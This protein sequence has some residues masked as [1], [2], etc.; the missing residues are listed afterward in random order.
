MKSDDPPACPKTK[1]GTFIPTLDDE[2]R[3][4]GWTVISM[5]NDWQRIFPFGS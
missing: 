4:N 5:K 1:I 2:A 3:Q